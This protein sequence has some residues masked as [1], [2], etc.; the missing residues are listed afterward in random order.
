MKKTVIYQEIDGHKVVI[1]T[2]EAAVDPVETAKI[3][4]GYIG[5]D[6]KHVPGLLHETDEWKAAGTKKDEYAKAYRA[7]LA[8]RR[9]NDDGAYKNALTAMENLQEELMP[10][11][12]ALA[13]KLTALRRENAV[14]FTPRRGEVIKDA[15]DVHA[16]VEDIKKTAI[17]DNRG[18]VF[19]RKVSK[20][21]QRTTVVRLGDKVPAG[22]ILEAD[23]TD[24]QQGEIE[25]ERVGALPAG[26]KAKEKAKALAKV[27]TISEK[28]RSQLEIK[29]D[30]EALTKA[31]E[32]YQKEIDR[33]G[34]LY[35]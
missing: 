8:A 10:L 14:Y 29:G 9:A 32:R 19:Y 2:S 20:K 4:D 22:A 15:S 3:V 28:M 24:A 7:M 18:V 21:W 34:D 23:L 35:G 5:A 26:V 25:R 11:A 13:D 31:K 12:R 17:E 1:G 16:L 27:L 6:G 33:I 30:P